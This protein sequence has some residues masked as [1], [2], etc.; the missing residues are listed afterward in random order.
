MSSKNAASAQ[1]DTLRSAVAA[2]NSQLSSG[3][4]AQTKAYTCVSRVAIF[5][6]LPFVL[7]FF[8]MK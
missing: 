6:S 3:D 8:L 7:L 4:R 5:F 2:A 1:L